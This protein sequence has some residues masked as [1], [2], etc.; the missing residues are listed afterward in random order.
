MLHT[1]FKIK[2]SYEVICMKLKEPLLYWLKPDTCDEVGRALDSANIRAVHILGLIIADPALRLMDTKPELMSRAVLYMTIICLG[3]PASSVYNFGAAVLRSVGDSKTPL[4]ILSSSG[5][6]WDRALR[7][8]VFPDPVPPEI[9]ILYFAFTKSFNNNEASSEREPFSINCSIV[10]GFS[11]NF[12]MEIAEPS[13]EIGDHTI[14]T[15]EPSISLLST[16][17]DD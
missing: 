13:I 17:G 8:V 16:I 14:F 3:I 11:G 9:K 4:F 5:I 7:N 10:K 2:Y 15:R 6:Y 12:L 1:F